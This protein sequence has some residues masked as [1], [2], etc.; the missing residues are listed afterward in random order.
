MPVLGGAE[1]DCLMVVGQTK[2][3]ETEVIYLVVV[4]Q[5]TRGNIIGTLANA[6]EKV[7]TVITPATAQGNDFLKMEL[8]LGQKLMA[9]KINAVLQQSP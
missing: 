5:V 1:R 9:A 8:E 4:Y 6:G 7:L 2:D 3:D